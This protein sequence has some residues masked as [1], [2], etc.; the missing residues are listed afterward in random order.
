MR[1]NQYL[2]KQG[3]A[4]RRGADELIRAGK[5]FVN[6]TRGELGQQVGEKDQVEVKDS[7]HS[8]YRYYAYHKPK[9]II[10]HSPG[11]TETDI[12]TLVREELGI[13]GVFPI[14]RLDKASS[15]LIILTNDGR[16]TDRLLSPASNH[17]K[18]YVVETREPLRDSF[19]KHMQEGVEI[20]GYRTKPA[21]VRILGDR[22]FSI[23][24][25]EG[26]KHQIRRMVVALHNDVKELKRVRVMNV[27]LG[28]LPPGAARDI[29]GAELKSFLTA[30]GL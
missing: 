1:L 17:D 30:L 23:V 16:V 12:E 5:V 11:R 13:R 3:Y 29:E 10:T 2:A 14:G 22:S 9:G 19:K 4:T 8:A 7:R 25:T 20:E 24:L 15:G 6:G 21:K 28:G 18:E 26:K 27:A